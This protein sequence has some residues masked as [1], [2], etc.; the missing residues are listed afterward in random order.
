MVR[1]LSACL[2]IFATIQ[3]KKEMQVKRQ[4][5]YGWERN[6]IKITVVLKSSIQL[7]T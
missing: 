7:S 6:V 2:A 5:K 3:S 1:P 4:V